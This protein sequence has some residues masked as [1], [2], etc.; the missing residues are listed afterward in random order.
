MLSNCSSSADLCKEA[1]RRLHVS[2][3]L[4]G[5]LAPLHRTVGFVLAVQGQSSHALSEGPAL[6]MTHTWSLSVWLWDAPPWG[7]HI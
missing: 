2:P 6:E 3:W 4:A 7:C 5:I 1:W